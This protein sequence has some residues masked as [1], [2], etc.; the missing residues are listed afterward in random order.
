MQDFVFEV[1]NLV[2]AVQQ[3]IHLVLGIIAILYLI[4]LVNALLG[5]RLNILGIWPRSLHG[6]PGIVFCPFL[7]G[8]FNHLFFNSIPLFIL[9][10]I[11][12]LKGKLIFY[13]VTF[14]ITILSG[15]AVWL[16]GRPAI[17]VG[18]SS[19]IMGYFGYLFTEAYFHPSTITIILAIVCVYYFGGLIIAAIIP[20]GKQNISWEGHILGLVAGFITAYFYPLLF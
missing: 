4:N 8:N 14:A 7:H 9:M 15:F 16:L 12:L 17:H 5:Y 2:A 18:A 20:N 11:I 13:S 10:N 1:Q 19:L 6:L 3:N